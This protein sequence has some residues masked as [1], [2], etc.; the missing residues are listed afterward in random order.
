M[1]PPRGITREPSRPTRARLITGAW[2]CGL[3][4]VLYLDRICMSQAIVPI[5]RDFEL[6]NRSI[7]YVLMAFTLAYGICEVPAGRLGDLL[8]SR[9]VLVRI[10][11][12]WSAF[13]MLTG[14]CAGFYSLLIVR[15]L[16]GAGEAGALPNAGRVIASWFPGSERGR[17]QGVMLASAQLGGVLAPAATAMLIEK[18]GWRLSF[19][20]F[21][22]AGF[23]WA[24]GFWWWF[25]DDPSSHA[26][27][28][29]AELESIRGDAG[30][31][32]PCHGP[33][34]WR[35]ALANRG[36]L[37]LGLIAIL[38]AFYT[39]F[40]Y[41]WFPKY[42]MAAHSVGN[43]A[44][45]NLAS[46]V[47]AGSAVGMLVG[48]WLAD[49]IARAGAVAGRWPGGIAAGCYAI[50]AVCLLVGSRMSDPVALSAWWCASFMMMHVTLPHWWVVATRQSG[51]H[52][53]AILGLLN[54]VGIVGA[55]TSQWLVGAFTD[56]RAGQ[57]LDPRQQ[58]DPL[59]TL[60]GAVLLLNAMAWWSYRFKAIGDEPA[61]LN[62]P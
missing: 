43:Q 46:M 62:G 55:L 35:I 9:L 49:R 52:V 44:A 1:D 13:T 3:A 41:S 60:Y 32:P 12:W 50:S 57:N 42:L 6:D 20:V 19:S 17:M 56:W 40:F 30:P 16:F 26:S 27:V 28:N 7:S 53:G 36:V 31:P 2:L 23:A 21:A 14:A 51:S 45:G 29:R 25:R 58:W 4:A 5:Q 22:F 47:I 59:F 39:Y 33:V 24:A 37:S 18:I 54:G 11:A 61:R 8:G 15:F 38:A 34:P 10:V 48:G